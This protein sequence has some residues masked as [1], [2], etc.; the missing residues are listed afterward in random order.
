MRLIGLFLLLSISTML[1]AGEARQ[2]L[3]DFSNTVG[4]LAGSF[5]QQVFD[6]EGNLRESSTGTLALT[7]PN[8]FRW[9][10]IEPF[11]QLIVADG[12]RVWIHDPDLEQVTVRRQDEE[13]QRSPLSVLLDLTDLDRLYTV[14]ELPAADGLQWLGLGPREPEPAFRA[15][16]LGL[17]ASGLKLMELEDLLGQRTVMHFANWQ[18]NPLFEAGFFAFQPPPG[19]DVVGDIGE[20][21]PNAEI[22]PLQ[23]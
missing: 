10:Y 17:D 23:D 21:S 1:H 4:G 18:R 5:E 7:R 19:T 22:L 8:R 12:E 16:R 14:E 9:E 20:I 11:P 13:E 15:V 3:D 6:A 2:R